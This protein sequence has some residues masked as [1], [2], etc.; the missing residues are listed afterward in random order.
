MTHIVIYYLVE[1][2]YK[3]EQMFKINVHKICNS[4]NWGL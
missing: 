4:A 3:N 1:L 2:G